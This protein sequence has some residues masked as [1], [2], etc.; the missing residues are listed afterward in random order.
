[1]EF[2]L[3]GGV[4][5]DIGRGRG[6]ITVDLRYDH[7]ISNI[8]DAPTIIDINGSAFQTTLSQ[9]NR[10]FMLIVGYRYRL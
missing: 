10:A 2:G 3:I 7:G 9:T 4:G 8:N 6:V 5:A 1:M